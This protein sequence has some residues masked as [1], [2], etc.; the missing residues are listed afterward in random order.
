VLRGK[1][2]DSG[3]TMR[4]R[5]HF[6]GLVL[7]NTAERLPFP[8]HGHVILAHPSPI[9]AYP[10]SDTGDVRVLVDVAGPLPAVRTGAMR[11]HLLSHVLPQLPQEIREPFVEAVEAGQVRSMP[12][13]EMPGLPPRKDGVLLLGD[14]FNCRHPLTGGGMTVALSDCVIIRDI[15]C[16]ELPD[17]HDP[18]A[19]DRALASFYERRKPMAATINILAAALY[20]VFAARGHVEEMRR[21]CFEYFKLGGPAVSGPIGLLS[22]TA[23][24]PYEL[25]AHFFAVAV[26]GAL[27]MLL[28]NP[29]QVPKAISMIKAAAM[30]V[31]PLMYQEK[32][33]CWLPEF[34]LETIQQTT[35]PQQ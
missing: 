2:G 11:T 8:G 20:S 5:S 17:L 1:V 10:I 21:A 32:V 13:R 35:T 14:A 26:F 19:L 27:R 18:A 3:Q 28:T 34:G 29:F 12:N 25:L 33:L 6:V 9:L 15:L 22:G 24:R 23:P 4:T 16:R 7:R 31:R 30:I